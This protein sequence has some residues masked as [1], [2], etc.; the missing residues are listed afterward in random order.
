MLGNSVATV[1]GVGAGIALSFRNKKLQ[2]NIWRPFVVCTGIGT[3]ADYMY[4]Y[5]GNCRQLHE[6]YERMKRQHQELGK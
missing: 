2:K 1:I 3:L 4:G 5:F 6:D